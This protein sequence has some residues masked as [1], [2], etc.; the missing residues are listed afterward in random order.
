MAHWGW[1]QTRWLSLPSWAH[2]SPLERLL[3]KALHQVTKLKSYSCLLLERKHLFLRFSHKNLEFCF[4]DFIKK[5]WEL[6]LGKPNPF[7]QPDV[8]VRTLSLRTKVEM[9]QALCDFRLTADD[10][11][12]KLKVILPWNMGLWT[13]ICQTLNYMI[14]LAN[15]Q[16][17]FAKDADR[18]RLKRR[19][20]LVLLRNATLPRTNSRQPQPQPRDFIQYFNA[21]LI[22]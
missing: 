21:F 13:Q 3:S 14:F 18:D 22:A 4:R 20:V 17:W 15:W 8:N 1:N 6:R 16:R 10:V 11:I 5:Q 2:S 7:Y 9:M 19:Q 12:D